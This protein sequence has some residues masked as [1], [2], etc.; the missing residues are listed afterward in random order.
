[1]TTITDYLKLRRTVD[2]L[3]DIQDVRMRTANRL[4]LM[5]KKTTKLYVAPLLEIEKDLTKEIEASL[6][7]IPIYDLW[8]QQVKGVGP[9]LA[10]SIIAHTMIRF[11][12][13][14]A[15]EYK[16]MMS[17]VPN[18]THRI[19]ASHHRD[20]TQ[21][22]LASQLLSETQDPSASHSHSETQ[23]KSASHR[24]DETQ[25]SLASHAQNETQKLDASQRSF[26]TQEASASHRGGETQLANASHM[27]A[28]THLS[29]AFSRE[30]L[31]L[32]QKTD[33]GEYLIPV[34]RG[35]GAF[36]TVS[37]LWA[38]WGLH[39]IDG[40]APKR[41][42]G[43]RINW[44]SALRTLAWKIGKQFVLQGERY[45]EVYDEYKKRLSAARLPIG[46]CPEYQKCLAKMKKRKK[47]A[48]KGHIDA[49]ARRYAVKMFLSHLW[50]K[51]RELEGLPI[52]A[53]YVI[54][55]LGHTTKTAPEV[56]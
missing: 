56:K 49:M 41:S 40:K 21:R 48:C 1:M 11:E 23:K 6:L 37:K 12:R 20:E 17:Q 7:K 16:R 42:R 53:P 24:L 32:A 39:V 51:W 35:I 22:R 55:K 28:E 14:S 45:R 47:P 54:D 13:V 46:I 38:W 50:E 15:S 34:I 31:E 9:R 44:N 10:G 2:V 33:R 27:T 5:P 3:Y 25:R 4:R 30:Q 29:R 52:R 19:L 18:E 26:E 8:L 36:D 43:E